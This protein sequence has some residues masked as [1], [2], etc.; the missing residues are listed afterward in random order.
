[1][2]HLNRV[3]MTITKAYELLFFKVKKKRIPCKI[4]HSGS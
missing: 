4:F 2:F 3:K 1:M